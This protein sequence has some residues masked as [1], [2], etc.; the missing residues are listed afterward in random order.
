MTI[1]KLSLSLPKT[2]SAEQANTNFYWTPQGASSFVSKIGNSRLGPSL[3]ALGPVPEP[4]IEFMRLAALVYAADRTVPRQINGSNWSQ[5]EFEVSVPVSNPLRWEP[6]RERLQNLVGFLS[7]DDWSFE[8]IKKRS[9]KEKIADAP[10]TVNRA[11]LLSGGADSAAGALLSR[12]ELGSEP[13]VLVSHF[14]PTFLP[15][16][17]DKV[18]RMIFEFAKGPDQPHAQIH[19]SRR[20]KQPNGMK[21]TDEYSTRSRSLLFLALGLA[22]ASIHDVP[23][24]VPEN[25]FASLNPPLGP[26]R[27]G[28]LS[29]HTTHPY[30]LEGLANVLTEADVHADFINP[31]SRMTKGEMFRNASDLIGSNAAS[32]FL[33]STFSCTNTDQRFQRMPSTT[34]CG[35]CFGCLVRRS[36]FVAAGLK[37]QTQYLRGLSQPRID[38]YLRTKSAENSMQVFIERGIK[39]ADIAA[40]SLP[41][42]YSPQEALDLCQRAI[43]EMRAVLV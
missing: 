5:R 11:V 39:L 2:I 23:L 8:F 25:G 12:H 16:I 29:T 6:I 36:A 1:Y 14:G 30:F 22:I 33:S 24:W 9:P 31:F 7:G 43:A 13:H 17:Q 21:F 19:F 41:D 35:V 4:N 20:K 38:N 18:A 40:L 42:S 3:G 32:K 10:P 15:H 28:S 26:D 27:R 34:H 37:D